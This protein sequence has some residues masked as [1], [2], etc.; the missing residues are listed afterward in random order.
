MGELGRM[1]IDKTIRRRKTADEKF[2]EAA[3]AS[4]R[5]RQRR[6]A[7]TEVLHSLVL[8]TSYHFIIK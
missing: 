2:K 3:I 6:S 8:F 7:V 1:L 5:Y 4:L